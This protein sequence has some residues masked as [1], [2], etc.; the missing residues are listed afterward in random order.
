[1]N[2]AVL[3]RMLDVLTPEIVANFRKAI[4]LG[5]W[6]DGQRLTRE[7]LETCL[8]A[9]IAWEVKNL[10]ETERS[11]YIAKQEKEGEVCDTPDEEQN[12]KFLH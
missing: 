12:V 9:V 7:Q 2:E 11:G 5:K 1:M 10:P 6:Q 4:E 3:R 8:Q